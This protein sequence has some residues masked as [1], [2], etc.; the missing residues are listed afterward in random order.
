MS[1]DILTQI[2]EALDRLSTSLFSTIGALQRDAQ[3][4]S[5]RGEPAPGQ[6]SVGL[7]S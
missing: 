5:I 7:L 3:P 2:Q 1:T 4:A 6:N